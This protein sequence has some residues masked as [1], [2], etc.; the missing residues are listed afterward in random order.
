MTK[1]RA[2]R[3]WIER[4]EVWPNNEICA[5]LPGKRSCWILLWT[6]PSHDS[7]GK[8]FFALRKLATY[9]LD[10]LFLILDVNQFT[11]KPLKK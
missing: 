9:N 6:S 5:A 1:Q 8:L 10:V 3:A 11:N 2:W 4:P 7:T